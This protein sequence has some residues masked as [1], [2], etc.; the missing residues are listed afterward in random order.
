MD[1]T[2]IDQLSLQGGTNLSRALKRQQAEAR[3]VASSTRREIGELDGLIAQ[4]IECCKRGHVLGEEGKPKKA[5]PAF[6][7]LVMLTKARA[8][9]LKG[10]DP[11]KKSSAELI[12]EI[13]ELIG[14]ETN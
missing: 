3:P 6:H 14:E 12:E 10:Y 9:L 4:A 8:L 5:N 1:R 7:H 2:P 11:N 13:D